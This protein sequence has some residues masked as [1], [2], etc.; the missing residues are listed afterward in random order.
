MSR[1]HA[2]RNE[3]AEHEK[4]QVAQ[5]EVEEKATKFAGGHPPAVGGGFQEQVG[6]S[7]L[8]YEEDENEK[9]LKQKVGALVS[10]QFGGDYKKAFTH[11]DGDKDGA[12]TKG[13]LVQL[14]ED[15]GV[16]NGITRGMW[17]K[18]IIAK[19]DTSHDKGIQ[20][21]EFESVFRARA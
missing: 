12:V 16:G 17:A 10:S 20:W 18:G 3:A 7:Q 19:L 15:A 21:G 13:E 2:Q 1:E 5:A 4:P 6:T 9:E 11:Y 8:A 14:L